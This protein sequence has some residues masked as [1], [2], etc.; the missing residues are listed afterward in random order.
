MEFYKMA[1]TRKTLEL[2]RIKWDIQLDS[3]GNISFVSGA[4]ATAQNV[5]NE[6][7][8]FTEDA[9]F[10]SGNG[11]PHFLFNLGRKINPGIFRQ[12][13]RNAA[14]LVTDVRQVI[15]VNIRSINP[16]TRRLRG[17]IQFSTKG[18]SNGEIRTDF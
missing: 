18:D 14:L 8:L 15:S 4:D 2:D 9:Y 1:H 10:S 5:S 17:D 11:I 3:V 13:L 12:Y 6:I 7:R 16:K